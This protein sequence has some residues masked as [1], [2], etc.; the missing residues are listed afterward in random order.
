MQKGIIGKKRDR[1]F[2]SREL[3]NKVYREDKR[4][5]IDAGAG[6][7]TGTDKAAHKLMKAD[8]EQHFTS[9]GN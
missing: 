3:A 1:P 2:I 6:P 8:N 5:K 7:M 4:Q 9:E